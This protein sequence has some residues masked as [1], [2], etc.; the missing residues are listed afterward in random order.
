M[1]SSTTC[2]GARYEADPPSPLLQMRLDVVP[3]CSF[4]A[5][6]R[7]D[8]QACLLRLSSRPKLTLSLSLVRLSVGLLLSRCLHNQSRSEEPLRLCCLPRIR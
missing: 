5:R 1:K 3:I 2:E 7:C 8:G 6:V 4:G